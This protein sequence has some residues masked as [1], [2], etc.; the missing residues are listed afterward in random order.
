MGSRDGLAGDFGRRDVAWREGLERGLLFASRWGINALVR[1]GSELFGEFA[2][3]FAWTLAGDS[4]DL[5][6]KQTQ[7]QPV[8]VRAPNGAVRAQERRPG[9]FFTAESDAAVAQ[10][11]HKPLES[12]RHLDECAAKLCGDSIDHRRRHECLADGS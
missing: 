2:V 12:N 1:G 3:A 8:L 4:L 11:R 5:R 10:P 9:A 6:G 7:D